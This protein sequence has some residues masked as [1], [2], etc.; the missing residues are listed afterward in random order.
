MLLSLPLRLVF[1]SNFSPTN[2]SLHAR[3]LRRVPDVAA[4]EGLSEGVSLSFA[5]GCGG[6]S[7]D[8]GA[9]AGGNEGGG[10]NGRF[11]FISWR[12]HTIAL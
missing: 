8:G 6:G 7:G 2:F 9:G 12:P 10:G 1:F 11:S 3:R 4:A 5:I